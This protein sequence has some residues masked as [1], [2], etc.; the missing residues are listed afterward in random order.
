MLTPD[1]IIHLPYSPDLTQA[2]LAYAC[3]S[4]PYTYNRMGGSP[5]ER[6]R[7][8][9][10]G[11][12]VELAF[13]RCLDAQ[14][15]PY[16]TL[17]VTPF[18]EPDR[19]D[20]ALGGRR[21]DVKSFLVNQKNKIHLLQTHPEILLQASALVPVDQLE[22]DHVADTDLFIFAFISG[23]TTP[24]PEDVQRALQARQPVYLIYPLPAAWSH[25]QGWNSMGA[26]TLKTNA[27][28]PLI[29]ELGGQNQRREYQS[30]VLTLPPSKAVRTQLDFYSLAFLHTPHL[31]QA[32]IGLHCPAVS[33]E[34]LILSESLWGN[35]W[36]YGV[37]I[38]LAGY[39][40]RAEFR[41][42]AQMLPAASRVFQ[43]AR[44]RVKN[45]TLPISELE[46]LADLFE[47]TRAWAKHSG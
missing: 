40:T 14:A 25:P 11:K 23:L 20:A 4:L 16:D 39:I 17:G 13:R 5:L 21:C 36:V 38:L 22:S 28:G 1:E 29:V 44:T 10:A 12:A 18:T 32:K 37:E 6:L 47:R 26:I 45:Y 24:R 8:I 2:G 9:T 41:Q 43:Y 42:R 35:I 31:P 19:Y 27:D 46:P 7:R 30:E 33:Q 34:P 3:R 15:V